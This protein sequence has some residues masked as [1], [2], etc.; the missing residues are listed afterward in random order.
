MTDTSKARGRK[1]KGVLVINGVAVKGTVTGSD[2]NSH[3]LWTI[4]MDDGSVIYATGSVMMIEP[5]KATD[6]N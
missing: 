3:G 5:R 4:T 2:Y 1:D 6:V